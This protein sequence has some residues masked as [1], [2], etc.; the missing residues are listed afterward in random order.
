MGIVNWGGKPSEPAKLKA[1]DGPKGKRKINCGR[2][3]QEEGFC[4]HQC[5]RRYAG[6]LRQRRAVFDLFAPSD[7]LVFDPMKDKE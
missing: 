6:S 1:H 3:T 7:G 4:W 2:C 5:R